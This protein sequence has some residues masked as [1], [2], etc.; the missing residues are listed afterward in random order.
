MADP[1][2]FTRPRRVYPTSTPRRLAAIAAVWPGIVRPKRWR[3]SMVARLAS[4]LARKK[5]EK[6]FMSGSMQQGYTGAFALCAEWGNSLRWH[7]VMLQCTHSLKSEP[8]G[9]KSDI[10]CNIFHRRAQNLQIFPKC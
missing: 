9:V 3:S 5:R 10:E 2:G 6:N 8:L 7:I 4:G 1:V